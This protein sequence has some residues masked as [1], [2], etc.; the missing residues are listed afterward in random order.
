[1]DPHPT[2]NGTLAPGADFTGRLIARLIF[3]YD[4]S[5]VRNG[6]MGQPQTITQGNRAWK[7]HST[8]FDRTLLE[9]GG[10]QRDDIV[11]IFVRQTTSDELAQA[12]IVAP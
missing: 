7:D 11:K 6:A 3:A 4:N 9:D 8:R 12:I 1:M 5:E 2:K 10:Y